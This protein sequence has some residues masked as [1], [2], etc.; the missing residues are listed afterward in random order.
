MRFTRPVSEMKNKKQRNISSKTEWLGGH[1]EAWPCYVSV[2]KVDGEPV[3]Y[4][5]LNTYCLDRLAENIP[6][7]ADTTD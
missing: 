7:T 2:I 5:L 4:L 3:Y 6:T 1:N